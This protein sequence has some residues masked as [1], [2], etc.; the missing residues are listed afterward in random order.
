[1]CVVCVFNAWIQGNLGGGWKHSP[2]LELRQVDLE[3][4]KEK[5]SSEIV[6]MSCKGF[7]TSRKQDNGC[8]SVTRDCSY[9]SVF[10]SR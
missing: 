8:M 7:V 3:K 2:F 4:E 5:Q 6:K 1:M 10:L 9:T